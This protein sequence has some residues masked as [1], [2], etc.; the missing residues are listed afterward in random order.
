MFELLSPISS[1]FDMI[2][3]ELYGF[4][5]NFGL[6][7]ILL[8]LMIKLVTFP[9]NNKQIQSSKKMQEVQ[10]EMKKIQQK[11]KNDKQK[12]NEEVMKFMQKNKV[13]PMAGCLPLLVQMPI[14][15]SLFHLLRT[16]A[17]EG[18]YYIAEIEP[19]LIPSFEFLDLL[20]RNPF[21]LLSE[22]A[23]EYAFL[24]VLAGITTFLYQKMMMTDPS[25]KM[26][27]IMMP[28]MLFFISFTLPAGVVLYWNVNN[29]FSIGQHFLLK[30][31]K[32]EKVQS[33]EIDEPDKEQ[34][35]DEKPEK[36]SEQQQ[37]QKTTNAAKADTATSRK[38]G[39]KKKGKKKKGAQGRK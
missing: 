21:N 30:G 23:V 2:L 16:A 25:Q 36:K 15:I 29:V 9:L 4:T 19:Y 18:G 22:G 27:F 10:P 37:L 33:V 34:K 38:K 26:L 11:Y 20:Y 8:T 28:A 3:N 17:D 24:P 5:Q 39:K 1:F 12:Q 31:K 7:I 6:S 14:L 35:G 13:N 32:D